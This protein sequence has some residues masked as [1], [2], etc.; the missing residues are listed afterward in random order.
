MDT[1]GDDNM[2][3]LIETTKRYANTMAM[4]MLTEQLK[5]DTAPETYRQ[6]MENLNEI[7][8]FCEN[9]MIKCFDKM[10]LEKIK[11]IEQE[12]LYA[13]IVE[14]P[15][16]GQKRTI[17]FGK[18]VFLDSAKSETSGVCLSTEGKK[19]WKTSP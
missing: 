15:C 2:K 1:S 12:F 19:R 8:M 6:N 4:E 14:G 7:K 10:I 13:S 11:A 16:H 3:M 17:I 18:R 5:K 9:T